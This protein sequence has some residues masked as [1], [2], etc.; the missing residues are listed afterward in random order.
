MLTKD[1]E[2]THIV[3]GSACM[4]AHH[5]DRFTLSV[6]DT[7][8]GGGMSSRLFQEIRE[9]KGL[10]Y[11]VFSFH[12]LYQD[13]GQ[14]ASTRARARPTPSRSCASFKPRSSE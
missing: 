9:K 5:E 13:T 7:I 14:F 8:L 10:A 12:S 4:N 1:T 11:A 3:Y 6:L 2:Q